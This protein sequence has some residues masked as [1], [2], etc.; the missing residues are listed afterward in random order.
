MLPALPAGSSSGLSQGRRRLSLATRSSLRQRLAATLPSCSGRRRVR[1]PPFAW[2]CPGGRSAARRGSPGCAAYEQSVMELRTQRFVSRRTE[3][4]TTRSNR[5]LLDC[6]RSCCSDVT[7]TCTS[8]QAPVPRS[9]STARLWRRKHER[10]RVRSRSG[11]V[12]KSRAYESLPIVARIACACCSAGGWSA[13]VGP[14]MLAT[15]M[16]FI[17]SPTERHPH[18]VRFRSS[19]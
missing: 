19:I 4:G 6:R 14:S 13:N 5:R 11:W 8:L 17:A 15:T 18:R 7:A 3:S 10:P 1:R 16:L 9:R 12:V 2:Q